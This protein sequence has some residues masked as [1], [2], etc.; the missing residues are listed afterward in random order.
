[1]K[2]A[3]LLAIYGAIVATA[4][5]LIQI[6]QWRKEQRIFN[7]TTLGSLSP[8]WMEIYV[9]NVS[10]HPIQIAY[11]GAAARYLDL[12]SGWFQR[13]RRSLGLYRVR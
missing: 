1:M 7:V 11:M 13:Q 9:T 5:A 3:D 12:G 4:I 8:A 6:K 2:A 10:N